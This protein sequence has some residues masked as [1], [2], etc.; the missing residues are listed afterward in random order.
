MSSSTNAVADYYCVSHIPAATIPGSR[1]SSILA[2]MHQGQSLTKQSLDYLQQQRLSEL[3]RL[4][5]GEITYETYIS[6]VDP[7]SLSKH[8]AASAANEVREAE[9]LALAARYSIRKT[10]HPHG[11]SANEIERK[12]RRQ[13]ERE[14]DVAGGVNP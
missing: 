11:D 10:H 13:R 8:Q 3:Y 14:A 1:L 5:C 7:A 2:R 4:A 6:G 9:L 12:L